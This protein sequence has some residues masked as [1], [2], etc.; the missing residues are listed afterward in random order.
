MTRHQLNEASPAE[1]IN[2]LTPDTVKRRLRLV[3]DDR[4]EA[5]ATLLEQSS[6]PKGLLCLLDGPPQRLCSTKAGLVV[7]VRLK[8]GVPGEV[9]DI[10]LR[11]ANCS[12]VEGVRF[13]CDAISTRDSISIGP[14][15]DMYSA[16]W[17]AAQL[18]AANMEAAIQQRSRRTLRRLK[19]ARVVSTLTR[20]QGPQCGTCGRHRLSREEYNWRRRNG[21]AVWRCQHRRPSPKRN[22]GLIEAGGVIAG[23]VACICLL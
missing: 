5:L 3:L 23:L 1:V 13:R 14:W 11:G 20:R 10:Q 6:N 17:H 7:R 18:I 8:R 15:H 19:S 2:T 4:E 22:R 21:Y 16:T 12:L 9:M